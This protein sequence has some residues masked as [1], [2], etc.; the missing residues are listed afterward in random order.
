MQESHWLDPNQRQSRIRLY[1]TTP[2]E[3]GVTMNRVGR[4][5]LGILAILILC[6]ILLSGCA[7][8]DKRLDFATILPE[9][10]TAYSISRLDTNADNKKDWVILYTYDQKEEAAF[11]PVGGVI[12]H[13]DRG[14][15][16]IIYPYPLVAPGWTYLG[17]GK[18]SIAV[19]EVLSDLPGPE[20]VFQS[21]NAQSI[22]THVV[23]FDWQDH[24]SD[25]VLPPVASETIGQ[26][27]HCVGQFNGDAGVELKSNQ[28]VVWERTEER[29]Q[30]SK[31]KT[32]LPQNGNYMQ[33]KELIPPQEICLDFAYGLPKE[34][35]KSPYPEKVLMAFYSNFTS[36]KAY[37]FLT[38]QAKQQMRNQE[39][40]WKN[41]APWPR[42]PAIKVCIKE[43]IYQPETE[44]QVQ[45][46]MVAEA[47]EKQI[48]QVTVQAQATQC[49]CPEPECTCPPTPT[50]VP[51]SPPV[52]VTV[53]VEYTLEDQ[54]EQ[55]QLRW[56]LVKVKDVWQIDR[57][58]PIE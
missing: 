55:M 53:R 14:E 29:S 39:G 19:K 52:W 1:T 21:V 16:P 5:K 35:E 4:L 22:T 23:L 13:A 37:Q 17:E 58:I 49:T 57:V 50:P 8:E 9:G 25:P 44:P 32:Y 46:T 51:T 27:Y 45:A 10:W 15:P 54:T 18:S 34:V 42:T 2:I 12:Y 38:A 43:L 26:W 24:A 31:R 36:E 56:G 20:V 6:G 3:K 33:D 48:A 41:I 30:L 40:N 11:T 7:R 28:V 47:Q